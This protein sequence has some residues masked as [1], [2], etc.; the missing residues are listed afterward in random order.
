[1]WLCLRLDTRVE[2][3]NDGGCGA[4][5]LA[6]KP[7]DE[8]IV[9]QEAIKICVAWSPGSPHLSPASRASAWACLSP[10]GLRWQKQRE[11]VLEVACGQPQLEGLRGIKIFPN[12]AHPPNPSVR[13]AKGRDFLTPHVPPLGSP[14]S[15]SLG[16]EQPWRKGPHLLPFSLSFWSP[17][18][19]P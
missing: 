16:P 5:Q 9:G 18:V 17:P 1:M 2:N 4:A 3:G 10:A 6:P 11:P 14:V 19:F 8:G 15:Y 12:P 13:C 7:Q